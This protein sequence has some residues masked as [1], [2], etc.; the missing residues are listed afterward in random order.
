MARRR[1]IST[2]ISTDKRVNH[3]A[4]D[5]GTFAVLLYTWMVPHA[6]DDGGITSDPDELRLLVVPGIKTNTVTMQ[7][8]I[9][10]MENLRLVEREGDRLFFPPDTFYKYQNYVSTKN[11][12]KSPENP[13]EPRE[14]PENPASPTP[15]PSLSFSPS[16]SV[17]VVDAGADEISQV[18]SNFARYGTVNALTVGYVDDAVE[19][20]GI[21]WV[22]RAVAV[23]AK[24]K[25]SGGQPPWSYVENTLKRWKTQGGPDDDKPRLQAVGRTSG[26]GTRGASPDD[27]T[28]SWERYAAGQ[29]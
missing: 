29:D 22:Q 9:S 16:P 25:A 27:V 5:A 20:Y 1:S 24:G 12:R 28:D 26:L 18:V 8:A 23:G 6:A 21:E 3:L 19:E 10:A 2:D 7:K 17:E 13:E 11:R 4:T 15:S 14:I